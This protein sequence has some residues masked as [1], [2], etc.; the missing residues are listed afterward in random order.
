MVVKLLEYL[1][2][3]GAAQ[4]AEQGKVAL[5]DDARGPEAE[6]VARGVLGHAVDIAANKLHGVAAIAHG[7][8]MAAKGLRGRTV[9]DSD[10][11]IG[12]DDSVL[13]WFQG[14]LCNLALFDDFHCDKA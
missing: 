10:E 2:A 3:L 13:A 6:L 5:A 11:I 1:L 14:T 4:A 12:D 7:P 9:D 8:V